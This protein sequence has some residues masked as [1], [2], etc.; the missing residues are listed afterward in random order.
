MTTIQSLSSPSDKVIYQ[1]GLNTLKYQEVE[2]FAKK[3]IELSDYTIC[4]SPV[5]QEKPTPMSWSLTPSTDTTKKTMGSLVSLLCNIQSI[6]E[7]ED[8]EDSNE[9]KISFKMSHGVIERQR[10]QNLFQKVIVSRNS[11]TH[12]FENYYFDSDSTIERKHEVVLNN[13]QNEYRDAENLLKKLKNELVMKIDLI[14]ESLELSLE[15]ITINEIANFFEEAYQVY[16]RE[17]GWAVWQQVINFAYKIPETQPAIENLKKQRKLKSPKR[18][19]ELV[20]PDWVFREEPTKNG[21]RILVKIDNSQVNTV[22]NLSKI[23]ISN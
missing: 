1:V 22:N 18:L 12:H 8:V 14:K 4:S 9:I 2:K 17:D 15:L 13:L 7:N 6:D 19:F 11:F 3:I 23:I 20:F 21:V 5:S 10:I 16:K